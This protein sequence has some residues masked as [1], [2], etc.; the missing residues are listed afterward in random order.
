M[1]NNHRI[2]KTSPLLLSSLHDDLLVK[3]VYHT[4]E[5]LLLHLYGIFP[6]VQVSILP[7]FKNHVQRCWI[8]RDSPL[9]IVRLVKAILF[10][11]KNNPHLP[12]LYGLRVTV[13]ICC[14]EKLFSE[15]PCCSPIN[16]KYREQ[17]MN[18]LIAPFEAV[19]IKEEMWKPDILVTHS[20]LL[21][22]FNV[23]CFTGLGTTQPSDANDGLVEEDMIHWVGRFTRGKLIVPQVKFNTEKLNFHIFKA[24]HTERFTYKWIECLSNVPEFQFKNQTFNPD[25]IFFIFNILQHSTRF[26]PKFLSHYGVRNQLFNIIRTVPFNHDPTGTSLY[27]CEKKEDFLDIR[28]Q[29]LVSW[30]HCDVYDCI[31]NHDK[32]V[33]IRY[34]PALAAAFRKQFVPLYWLYMWYTTRQLNTLPVSYQ[35]KVHSKGDE[36]TETVQDL[37]HQS[38]IELHYT[39]LTIIKVLYMDYDVIVPFVIDIL[40]NIYLPPHSV[41]DQEYKLHCSYLTQLCESECKVMNSH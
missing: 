3:H 13:L 24:F 39:V 16:R 38:L 7:I 4:P 35:F 10:C 23:Q 37:L 27:T 14:S 34:Q 19:H 26:A 41:D 9:Y 6:E 18:V 25:D 11:E 40:K 8:S 36:L 30:L 33:Y 5:E 2:T 22:Q 21:E 20:R 1:F 29:S 12:P 31:L 17:Y 15:T 32:I 28:K